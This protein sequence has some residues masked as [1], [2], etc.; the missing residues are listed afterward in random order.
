MRMPLIFGLVVLLLAT[1][2]FGQRRVDP[3]EKRARK[4]CMMGKVES[5]TAILADLFTE[6]GNP[7]YVFNQGRCFEQNGM[8][9]QAI[10]R[11]V[12]YRRIARDLPAEDRADVDRHIAECQAAIA[13]R[14][15][16]APAAPPALGGPAPAVLA[17]A[18]TLPAPVPPALPP[19]ALPQPVAP[20]EALPPPA[21]GALVGNSAEAAPAAGEQGST[22]RTLGIVAGGVGIASVVTGVVFGALSASIRDQINSDA[23]KGS[24]DRAKDDR[25]R[26]YADMQWVGYGVGAAAITAGALLYWLG[27]PSAASPTQSAFGVVPVLSASE[28]GVAVRGSF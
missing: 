20:T 8:H 5:G 28:T 18:P 21:G 23:K 4:D 10:L 24:Y 1:S 7:N 2:A 3:R 12:E 17:P 22:M 13:A 19:A 11:F 9:E 14:S 16:P 6:T 27:S 26:L 15:Q 25:G